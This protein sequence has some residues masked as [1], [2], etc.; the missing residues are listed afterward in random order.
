MTPVSTTIGI[1]VTG[2]WVGMVG[3]DQQQHD[4]ASRIAR[5]FVH[6][7]ST[8]TALAEY[9][10]ERPS[11][12]ED[13]YL[14]QD[15]AIALAARPVGGWKVGRINPPLGE[16]NRLAGPIFSD[17]IALAAP[18]P[19]A[20]PVFR[21]GFAAAEAEFLLRL[22][23]TPDPVKRCYTLGEARAL[24]DAVSVGIE[25]ASSP[26]P[27]INDNGPAVTVSDFGNNNG[28]VVGPEVADWRDLDLLAWP[29]QLT[30]NGETVG[31][32]TAATM[33]DGPFGA[34][35][36][37]LEHMAARG[38]PLAAGQWVSTGAVTGVHRVAVGDRVEARFDD[39]LSVECMIK[40]Q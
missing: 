4:Y 15:A 6:A 10:G 33:L 36:F 16:V 23:Q 31:Q 14:V 35:R 32:A 5:S 39:R 11:R 9:P 21:D 8:G 37:L 12:L 7:R 24:V 3:L 40:A 30:I 18:E 19:V 27:D 26:F 22:G 38:A 34:V 25:I 13:A 29:V 17:Q 28:L 2:T 1:K 20:M